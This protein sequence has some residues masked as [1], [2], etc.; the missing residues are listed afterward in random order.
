V[1]FE[2][3]FTLKLGHFFQS[4]FFILCSRRTQIASIMDS[5]SISVFVL[6]ITCVLIT[7][8]T[9]LFCTV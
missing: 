8:L 2:I 9:F 6:D 4:S 5:L 7:S 3:L 1:F